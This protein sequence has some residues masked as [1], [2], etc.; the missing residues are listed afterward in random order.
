MSRFR[1]STSR[2]THE[3]IR[4]LICPVQ[5]HY[6]LV[7]SITSVLFVLTVNA[8]PVRYVKG[9]PRSRVRISC[10]QR[11]SNAG[12]YV[13]PVSWVLLFSAALH[14]P[15]VAVVS[16]EGGEIYR[17][18]LGGVSEDLS[19]NHVLALASILSEIAGCD[20]LSLGLRRLPSCLLPACR[21]DL[22]SV[23]VF[24]SD[25]AL[26]WVARISFLL[27]WLIA[28]FST[29]VPCATLEASY[30]VFCGCRWPR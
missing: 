16:S 22:F 9:S 18:R 4:G 6:W 23:L 19:E 11:Y 30:V 15:T 2:R 24:C 13:L 20:A 28:P 14:T 5:T 25:S 3:S 27:R 12:M 17:G 21:S 29:E 7:R 8:N 26:A 1:A 10:R